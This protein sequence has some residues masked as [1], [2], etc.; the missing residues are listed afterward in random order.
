MKEKEAI[1]DVKQFRLN[2]VGY[3]NAIKARTFS[4]V[5]TAKNQFES[6][7]KSSPK[8]SGSAPETYEQLK[9][10]ECSDLA[11]CLE[12]IKAFLESG[13]NKEMLFDNFRGGTGPRGKMIGKTHFFLSTGGEKLY[14]N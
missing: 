13:Q 1:L 9:K 12:A 2:L 7:Y 14:E 8:F 4:E 3:P 5:C 11:E 6:V 10:V